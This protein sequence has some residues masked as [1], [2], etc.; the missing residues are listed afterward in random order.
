MCGDPGEILL[1]PRRRE[2][3][4]D[5]LCEDS[6]VFCKYVPFLAASPKEQGV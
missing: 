2:V 3:W 5:N 4:S 1:T 6:S